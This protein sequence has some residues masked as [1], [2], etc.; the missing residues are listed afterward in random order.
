[1][2][3][4]MSSIQA[5]LVLIDKQLRALLNKCNPASLAYTFYTP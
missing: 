2:A 5:R 4:F 3:A 1:M